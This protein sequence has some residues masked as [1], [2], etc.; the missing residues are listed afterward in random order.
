MT[1]DLTALYAIEHPRLINYCRRFT[2]GDRDQAEDHAQEAWLKFLE[3][4]ER[5]HDPTYPSLRILY[6]EAWRR[7]VDGYRYSKRHALLPLD[8]REQGGWSCDM[9]Q[10]LED[11]NV[12]MDVLA[13]YERAMSIFTPGQA[14]ALRLWLA[15]YSG[16][17]AVARLGISRGA[18]QLRLHRAWDVLRE[19]AAQD[20]EQGVG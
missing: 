13:I 14:Q 7:L 2:Y 16:K 12:K 5:F 4:R 17:E 20:I 19:A 8:I 3:W 6:G 9:A 11:I 10:V 15:G 1:V 18:Y